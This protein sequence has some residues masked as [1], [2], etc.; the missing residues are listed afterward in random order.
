MVKF[1]WKEDYGSFFLMKI[2]NTDWWVNIYDQSEHGIHWVK[3]DKDNNLDEDS[4]KYSW[5]IPPEVDTQLDNY[6]PANW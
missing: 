6:L 4:F 1:F 5:E 2:R 3:L